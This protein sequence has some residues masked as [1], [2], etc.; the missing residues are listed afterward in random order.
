MQPYASQYYESTP[1]YERFG[2]IVVPPGFEIY[3]YITDLVMPGVEPFRYSIS[4]RMRVFDYKLNEFVNICNQSTY[5]SVSLFNVYK[6]KSITNLLHRV[7]MITFCYFDGCLNYEVNH[8]DGNKYNCMPYNL[9]WSTHAQNM[10]HAQKY[11]YENKLSDN[12]IIEIIRMYNSNFAIKEIA[13]KFSISAGYV[14]D[15]IGHSGRVTSN[16]IEE[17]KKFYPITREK[18]KPIL[19]EEDIKSIA[20]RYN[21]GEEYYELALE[22]GVDRSSLT[23]QVK[24]YA[25]DHPEIIL[26]PLKKFTPDIVEEVCKILQDNKHMPTSELYNK[27]LDE[28]GFE[29]SISNRKAISNIFNNKTY[30]H[31]SSK[32]NLQ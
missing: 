28:I 29:R 30:K 27:C 15:I 23:K 20:I 8:I 32:Y 6:N 5:P 13:K 11:I 26:R 7:Y 12:D 14:S 4:N 24:R 2:N 21:S 31:I 25:K 9:E 17:I 19:S 18:K 16:R 10:A 3:L 1:F 22:F